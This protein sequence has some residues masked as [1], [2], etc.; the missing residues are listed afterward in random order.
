MLPRFRSIAAVS[1]GRA[2]A[3]TIS[4]NVAVTSPAQAIFD[5]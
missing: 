5:E 4:N 2:Q 1:G 3:G